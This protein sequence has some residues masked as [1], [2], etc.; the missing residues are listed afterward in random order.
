MILSCYEIDGAY[1]SRIAIA[2]GV[3]SIGMAG[4]WLHLD[5]GAIAT[6]PAPQAALVLEEMSRVLVNGP[7]VALARL[8]H[9]HALWQLLEA[10]VQAEIVAHRVL[11]AHVGSSKEFVAAMINMSLTTEFL[12]LA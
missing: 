7:V 8:A 12:T 1:H 3:I 6:R 9:A 10:L 2:A 11:P 5:L 4:I